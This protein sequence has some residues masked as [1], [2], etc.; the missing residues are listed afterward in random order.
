[1]RSNT[2]ED[3]NLIEN[4]FGLTDIVKVPR[5]YGNE[6]SSDEYK[7]GLNRIMKIIKTYKPK[8]IVFIYKKVLDNI[9]LYGFSLKQRTVY[10][11]NKDL[12]KLFNSKIFVFPMPGTP[13]TSGQA[14]IAMNELQKVIKNAH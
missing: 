2:F 5:N 14:I 10:G 8:V 7:D 6:P 12:E 13:C 3:E 9:L 1:V 4:N 11:F